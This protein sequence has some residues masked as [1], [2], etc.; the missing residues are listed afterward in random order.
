MDR[1]VLEFYTPEID[2]AVERGIEQNR[3]GR[4]KAVVRD[5]NGNPVKNAA[6]RLKQKT[7]EFRFGA[8]I[9]MLDELPTDE[10]N[11][12]YKEKFA[13]LFNLATLPFY[14][15][16]LEP[17]PGHTRYAA[18][19]EKIYRRPAPD[20]CLA[21][22][23]AHGIEPREHA[24]CYDHFFPTWLSGKSDF[25]V[26]R[27]LTRRMREISE[28]Y[29]DK[30]PTIE[31]T[32]ES[33][34]EKG[35]TDFYRS[36]EFVEWCFKTAE[37][38]FPENKLCINEWSEM[39]E[40]EGRCVDRYFMQVE[41][42]LLKGARI[43]AVGMQ[44]HMFYRE[45][46]YYRKTRRQYDPERQLRVLDNFARLGKP[47]QIT[48]ITVPAFTD[49][50]ADEQLQA[51]TIEKLYKL[52]FS[53]PAVEQIVYWNLADGYAAFTTPGNMTEGENYYRGGLLRYDLSEKPA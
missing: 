35:V 19:S 3:K 23:E 43:D 20:R 4:F 37:K 26:K 5:E 25:E 21:F 32:N 30:I 46:E 6:L 53:H 9:F 49:N 51:D 34:W 41:N 47:I 13:A 29:A 38:Y 16:A 24:L 12:I 39:W 22:C 40:G 44:F 1:K 42:A 15:D 36:P 11:A 31:V 2:A 18:D 17:T 45:E 52:W 33:Y 28:R 8:N 14:W 10:K 48:E 27:A 7:H 50:A